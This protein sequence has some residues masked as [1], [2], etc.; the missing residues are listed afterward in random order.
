MDPGSHHPSVK[1]IQQAVQSKGGNLRCPVCGRE[2]YAV[3]EVAVLS[4][5]MSYGA[6]R[7]QRAQLVCENCGNVLNFDLTRL[8]STGG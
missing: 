7:V 8:R 5:Q 4:A 3:E 6:H 1:E 2:E